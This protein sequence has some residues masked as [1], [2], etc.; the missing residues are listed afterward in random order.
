MFNIPYPLKSGWFEKYGNIKITYSMAEKLLEHFNN[1]IKTND[2]IN[3]AMKILQN[4]LNNNPKP[5]DKQVKNKTK[6]PN[7]SKVNKSLPVLQ[8]VNNLL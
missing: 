4:F 1:L 7:K 8:I 3:H 6:K 2:R 5:V